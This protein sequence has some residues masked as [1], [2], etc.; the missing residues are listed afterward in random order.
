METAVLN[1]NCYLHRA[2]SFST[3]R[4]LWWTQ[5]SPLYCYCYAS[6]LPACWFFFSFFFCFP[7]LV[8]S[9]LYLWESYTLVCIILADTQV[10]LDVNTLPHHVASK[11]L[12]WTVSHW[13]KSQNWRWWSW[14]TPN[15]K[16][17][18]NAGIPM[19]HSQRAC[20]TTD[21]KWAPSWLSSPVL[22]GC[23]WI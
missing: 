8:K 16:G 13:N 21:L 2:V 22:A 15:N 5:L 12:A 1:G 20:S 14:V 6:P 17:W 11:T 10:P 23:F 18:W 3:G 4:D 9:Y 19:I 7:I